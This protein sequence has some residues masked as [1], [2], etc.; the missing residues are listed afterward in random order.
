MVAVA[1][2]CALSQQAS[3]L[4]GKVQ[5]GNGTPADAATVVLLK[6]QDSSVVQSTI[7]N[8]QGSFDFND[9]K[10]G[11]YLIFITQLNYNKV[12]SGPY[13]VFTGQN[14][15]AGTIV[16]KQAA[17]QLAGITI[18]GKKDF[19]E[20][21]PDKTVL[22]VDQNIMA[23]G[24]S[25]YDVLITSPGVKMNNSDILYHG[26]Q[27][28]LIA[29]DGKPVLLSG[30]ELV[31]FLKNYQS[32]SI[33]QIELIDNPAS[34]YEASTSGGMINII[35]KKNT[36]LGSNFS[37]SQSAGLGDDYRYT[38]GLIYTL[39]TEKLN[40]FAS[41]GFQDSKV[42]HTISNSREIT[43]GGQVYTFD[44]NYLAHLKMVNNNFSVGADYQLAKGQTIG[45][46]VNGF[47]N[48]M[49]ID[50]ANTTTVTT[51]G[52]L[53]S[54]INTQSSIARTISN[55][56]YD[57]NY[58]AN[59]DKAGHS[60]LSGNADYADYHRHSNEMLQNVFVDAAGQNDGN[61]IYYQDISPSHI[62]IKSVNL[63]FTQQIAL[64]AHLDAGIKSSSVNSDNNIDFNQLV[65][66]SY[67]PDSALTDHFIYNEHID[68]AYIAFRGKFNQTTISA[69][70]RDERTSSSAFSASL[71]HANDKIDTAYNNLFT[72]ISVSQQ[73]DK[74]NLLTA[75]Y[76]RNIHRPDYQDLNPF[77]GYVDTY[78]HTQGNPFLKPAY[79][80]TYEVSD[81]I[82][83][84]YKV[85]LMEI[86]TDNFFATA[87]E[88]D[89]VTKVYTSTKIN[90][91]SHYQYQVEL[92]LPFDI[93]NW[94]NI[95]ATADIFHEKYTYTLGT[96][97]ARTT[98]GF[99]VYLNQSIRLSKRLNL[100]LYDKYESASYY[101][102]SDYR[103][104]FY[105]SAGLSY[106]VL[107]NKGSLALGWSDVFNTDYN[108]YH[109]DYAN[110]NITE[111]DRLST[112]MVQATFK[113]H[114]GRSS[115]KVRSNN[116]D[117]Q[118]RLGEGTEN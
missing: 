115:P 47:Y 79:I 5:T 77:V 1:Y 23:S 75:F 86:V 108:R 12:Y 100:Q 114:F 83:D 59:L 71:S 85:S 14:T 88:Q 41:Y 104:L 27:K 82:N 29:I 62:M 34:K 30:D 7:S 73:L 106:S 58:N 40:L 109:T 55:M 18:N 38:T 117:E 61:A 96:V 6:S 22:N 94:W 99:N 42:P 66:G 67:R 43:S 3:S 81:L 93:A 72:N 39:R 31:N 21:H 116:T 112:R 50:K 13:S 51:N 68:A 8:P 63:D 44:I 19:V 16:L 84:K 102:I 35:L 17:K 37:I 70:L 9:I 113:Y 103:P 101:I 57:L 87:F 36:G 32:S 4:H 110:L 105:M 90:L 65:G 64:S 24:S 91:G 78:Y 107:N 69:S 33:S 118:K 25:L 76:R 26:G 48:N 54:S 11:S 92:E 95:S 20:V 52:Q 89:N 28:A 60:I 53:D 80:N 46:L 15:N 49:P 111:R 74:H 45:F 10:P 2:N 97:P 98:D 56:S